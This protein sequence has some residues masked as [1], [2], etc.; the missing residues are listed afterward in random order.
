MKTKFILIAILFL[1]FV[2]RIAFIGNVPLYGDELTIAL[3]ASSILKTGHD[4][5]G[6]SLPLTFKMGAGRPAGY[7]YATIP[8]IVLFGSELGVRILSL[9]SG[10]GI[11]FLLYVLGKRLFSSNVGLAAAFIASISPWDINLSRAGF[12]SHFALFLALLGIVCFLKAEKKPIFY[13]LSALSFGVTLHTYP[14]YKVVLI[15]FLPLL[16]YFFGR[17][18]S[19]SGKKFLLATLALSQTFIGGSESRFS[20]INILSQENLK[21]SIEQKI[22]LERQINVLP[23]E[24]SK[25]FHNK[26]AE[27][28]KVFIE[29]YLQNFSM[30][31]LVIH[32]DRNPRHNMTTMGGIFF[33]DFILIII[34]LVSFWHL[35]KKIIMFLMFWLVIAPISTAI[36]DLPHGLR[37]AFMLPPL[38]IFSALG[39]SF[40]ISKKNR[41][42]LI[43]IS[44]IFLIQFTFFIQKLY[45][46]A[47]E[48]YSNFWSASAKEATKIVSEN[49][50]NFKY[51]FVSDKIDSLEFAYPVYAKIDPVDIIS[52][53]ENPTIFNGKK[54]KRYGNVYIG[55][56]STIHA[57]NLGGSIMKIASPSEK[58][59]LAGYETISQSDGLPILLLQRINN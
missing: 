5:L 48:E 6:N 10:I 9:L 40:I 17:S 11:I 56:I 45:F 26:T 22:N 53:N 58:D 41:I 42:L 55:D 13:I 12:E 34:G 39:L 49:K 54:Y 2:L 47:P 38:I 23:M 1:G 32:G 24:I 16:M 25:N 27:Y 31:F 14:T 28:A 4:Q 19:A 21:S 15:L 35:H 46:L 20:T 8:F 7:V 59:Q 52:Q 44:I 51:I 29:N 37:S 33:A 3:D 18:V 36:V 43:L 57:E 50:S 30:D